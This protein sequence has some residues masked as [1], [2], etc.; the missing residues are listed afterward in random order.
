[1]ENSL[2]IV[3]RAMLTAERSKGVKK[4]VSTAIS[5]AIFFGSRNAMKDPYGYVGTCSAIKVTK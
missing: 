1:M 2:P 3:G 4:P 5:S